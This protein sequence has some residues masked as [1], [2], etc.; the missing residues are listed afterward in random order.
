[1]AIAL[2]AALSTR[3]AVSERKF[4]LLRAADVLTAHPGLFTTNYCLCEPRL[5]ARPAVHLVGLGEISHEGLTGLLDTVNATI[6]SGASGGSGGVELYTSVVGIR[7]TGWSHSSSQD[8]GE[9]TPKPWVV[10]ASRVYSLAYSEHSSY[11]EL[12]ACVKM[13]RPQ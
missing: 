9:H 4:A 11:T 6:A 5:S 1:V 2:A 12:R 13:L 10:G 8:L 7:A 3:V